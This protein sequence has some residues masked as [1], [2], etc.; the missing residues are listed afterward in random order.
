MEVELQLGQLFIRL[1]EW[2][3]QLEERQR[4]PISQRIF[5]LTGP[6]CVYWVLTIP[7]REHATSA[8]ECGLTHFLCFVTP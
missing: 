2:K 1:A 7:T 5:E 6:I 4:R 8:L 3:E